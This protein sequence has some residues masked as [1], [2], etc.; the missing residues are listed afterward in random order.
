MT[1]PEILDELFYESLDQRF[2][3]FLRFRIDLAASQ[4]DTDVVL[5]AFFTDLAAR[6]TEW[7]RFRKGRDG[8]DKARTD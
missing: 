6:W 7:F 4:D 3:E 5:H 2:R 1:D 8:T